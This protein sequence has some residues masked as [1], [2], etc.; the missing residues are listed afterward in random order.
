MFAYISTA[1]DRPG[2]EWNR[3]ET[4][5]GN[6]KCIPSTETVV[7]FKKLTDENRKIAAIL[8]DEFRS[9]VPASVLDV[10]AGTGD[11]SFAA[12]LDRRVTL[13]DL[14]DYSAF[15]KAPHHQ[16]ILGDFFDTARTPAG[17]FD[18]LLFSH[19]LQ[20]LDDNLDLLEQRI[21]DFDPNF[22]VTVTNDN[23]DAVMRTILQFARDKIGQINPEA[24]NYPFHRYREVQA[25][26][27]T[28]L[29][30]ADSYE[31]LA[32]NFFAVILDRLL[33]HD[34]LVVSAHR[35]RMLAPNRPIL[36]IR[37]LVRG[38]IRDGI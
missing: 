32:R 11:I 14:L 13:I 31:E 15:P 22:L 21:A 35:F 37:Q 27:F 25:V 9:F 18:T 38:L 1:V 17:R 29:I 10:G 3:E 2:R 26:K 19:V 7:S 33:T 34:E 4:V 8:R 23:D 24:D 12:W 30:E 5:M 36:R 16:R 6:I 28:S 20:H